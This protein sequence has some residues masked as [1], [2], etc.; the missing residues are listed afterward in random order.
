MPS[1]DSCCAVG[2]QWRLTSEKGS[3]VTEAY[4]KDHWLAP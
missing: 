4:L 2:R 1:R 3:H